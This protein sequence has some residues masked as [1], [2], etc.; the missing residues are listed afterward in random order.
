MYARLARYSLKTYLSV[1]G[2]SAEPRLEDEALLLALEQLSSED[3]RLK[4]I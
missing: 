3:G 4:E 2:D 1:R